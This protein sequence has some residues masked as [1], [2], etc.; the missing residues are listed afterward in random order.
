MNHRTK[1]EATSSRRFWALLFVSV[2]VCGCLYVGL[3]WSPSSYAV[4]LREL[5]VANTGL[6]AGIPRLDRG[7]EFAWQTPLLQMTLRSGFRRFDPTP[8]YFEDLRTLYGMPILDGALV[9]KPQFWLFFVARPAIAYSFYHF[10][11]IAMFIV[12]FTVLFVRLGGRKPDSL[13]MA[14]VLYFSAYTQYWWDGAA[15]FFFPFF[16]WIVLAPMWNG[17]FGLRLLLFFW[18]LVSGLLTYFYPPNAIALGFVALVLWGA[19]RRDLLQWRQLIGIGL[20]AA[21]AGATVLFYLRDPI[22]RVADT[23]YPGHRISA[24]GGLPARMW[25][26]QMFPTSQM[27]HHKS[28]LGLNICEAS[29]IGSIYVLAALFFLPWSELIRTSTR[30]QRRRWAWLGIGLL[31]TQSWMMLPL[32][33]WVGYPL[34]WHLVPPGRMVLAGGLLLLVTVFVLAQARPPQLTVARCVGFALAL[35]WAWSAFKQPHGIGLGAAFR[36][37]IFIVP[38]AGVSTLRWLQMLTPARANTALLASATALGAISFGTYNPIQSTEPIFERHDTPVTAHIDQQLLRD[39]RGFLL[40]PWGSSFF[41]HSGLPL[42]A[43]G[44][45]SLSY[46]TFDPAT[47]LWRR[48]YPDL[49]PD[50]FRSMFHNAGSF[51]FGDVP[52]P[53]RVPGTLVTLSPMT[54]FMRQGATVCDFIRPSRAAFAASVGCTTGP[55]MSEQLRLAP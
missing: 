49:A 9:F 37:W 12:G 1:N 36:D 29:T 17:R 4:V 30:E 19:A 8:P 21:C 6:I 41:A 43:L 5:G 23:E 25:L 13:L 39:K 33:A 52:D 7:D 3:H 14:L 27:H 15:N 54:P 50:R 31:A 11:L 42:I 51:A 24:G 35:G 47:D 46:S 10:V 44:Y 53:L 28:L 22:A 32:P 40:I 38:V 20:A 55:A 18:L 26:T 34:L 48:V 45:P 2:V 16:P